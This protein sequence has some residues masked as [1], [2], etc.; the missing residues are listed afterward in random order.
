[1]LFQLLHAFN[2]IQQNADWNRQYVCFV[3]FTAECIFTAAIN[4]CYTS[5]FDRREFWGPCTC[6]GT[7]LYDEKRSKRQ[8]WYSTVHG[9][10]LN[11]GEHIRDL[12]YWVMGSTG[13]PPWKYPHCHLNFVF[14]GGEPFS[15]VER[16]EKQQKSVTILFIGDSVDRQFFFEACDSLRLTREESAGCLV[17]NSTTTYTPKCLRICSR[18]DS[19]V[20]LFHI[21]IFG[22]AL[23]FFRTVNPEEYLEGNYEHRLWDA[24]LQEGFPKSIDLL[25]LSSAFWEL[26]RWNLLFPSLFHENQ[27]LPE[28]TLIEY[29]QNLTRMLQFF[30]GAL[31]LGD[32]SN[33]IFHTTRTP[34]THPDGDWIL[35]PTLGRSA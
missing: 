3:L 21:S 32:T 6:S 7:G 4:L 30:Q 22:S 14:L 9:T 23:E 20:Q 2:L 13:Q 24:M 11:M 25:I 33:M 1:M 17:A 29:Q 28:W 16:I 5:W 15:I 10:G 31:P 18:P 12:G 27:L 34:K 35:D 8:Q 19:I 26:Y